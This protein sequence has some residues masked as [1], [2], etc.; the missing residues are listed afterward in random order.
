MLLAQLTD[1]HVL[2]PA[3]P[4]ERFVDNNARLAAAVAALNAENVRPD[5]V[6]ATGDLTDNGSEIEM[7]LVAELLE[8]LEIPLL[9]LPGNHDTRETFRATFDMPWATDDGHL[10]WT[11]EVGDVT[12]VGVDTLLPGSHGG[13]FDEDRAIWLDGVLSDTADRSVVVGMHHPPFES[14]IHWMDE[15]ALEGRDRFAE[16]IA[17]HDHVVRILCGHIHRPLVAT[18]GGVTTTVCLSTVQHV[19]LNL[20][21]AAP[22]ELIRDPVGYQLHHFDGNN[23]VTHNR[24]IETGEGPIRPTWA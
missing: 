6:I 10:G 23:W 5:V 12:I 22:V 11:V 8:P 1:T 24:Y 15:M 18:I 14:G 20:E 2:D 7:K 16:V 13:R 21:P 17:G 4:T 19:Q 9:P 3:S